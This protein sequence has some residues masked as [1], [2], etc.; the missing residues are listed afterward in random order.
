M[1]NYQAVIEARD[2]ILAGCTEL[3]HQEANRLFREKDIDTGIMSEIYSMKHWSES[4]K[5]RELKRRV[6]INYPIKCGPN[7]TT[8]TSYIPKTANILFS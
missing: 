3:H 2:F 7:N 8:G 6:S 5:L 1:A 4:M